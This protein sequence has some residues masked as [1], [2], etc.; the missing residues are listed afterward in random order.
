MRIIELMETECGDEWTKKIK[1]ICQ[2]FAKNRETF[3]DDKIYSS[4]LKPVIV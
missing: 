2:L 3:A 4:S 1:S